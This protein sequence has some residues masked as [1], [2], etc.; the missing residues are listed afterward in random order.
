MNHS[1][2]SL[3]HKVN[4]KS[5]LQMHKTCCLLFT[6]ECKEKHKIIWRKRAHQLKRAPP[7]IKHDRLI[8]KRRITASHFKYGKMGKLYSISLKKITQ[9]VFQVSHQL[10]SFAHPSLTLNTFSGCNCVTPCN[11]FVHRLVRQIG[12]HRNH[13]WLENSDIRLCTVWA[14]LSA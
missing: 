6:A 4:Q 11:H 1:W 10:V 8:K 12:C 7:I 13:N 5:I 14:C 9:I 3:C 2:Y